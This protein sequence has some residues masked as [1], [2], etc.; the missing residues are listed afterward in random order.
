MVLLALSLAHAEPR[1]AVVSPGGRA[2][3]RQLPRTSPD[4]VQW[5][6][7]GV[8]QPLDLE[9]RS[10]EGVLAW[11]TLGLGGGTW[12]VTAYLEPER[13]QTAS[14]RWDDGDVVFVIDD[15]VPQILPVVGAPELAD[16]LAGEVEPDSWIPPATPLGMLPGR[17]STVA[18]DAA[19]FPAGFAT[20]EANVSGE[21]RDLLIPGDGMAAIDRHR[22][23][24]ELAEVPYEE[25]AALFRLGEA[26]ARL[27]FHR[28][29][30]HYFE[31][32]TELD[33]SWPSSTWLHLARSEV[34]IGRTDEAREHCGRAVES[35]HREPEVL[36]C[37]A[38]VALDTADPP[39]APTGRAL[40]RANARPESLLLAAQLLQMDGRHL[41]AEPLLSAALPALGELAPY[42]WASLGDARF[43]THDGEG[44]RRAWSEVAGHPELGGVIRARKHALVMAEDGPRTWPDHLPEL[45]TMADGG[46]M[47]GAEAL[48]LLAQVAEG[49]GDLDGAAKH[50]AALLKS[51]PERGARSDAPKLLWTA[52]EGRLQQLQR[53]GR[54]VDLL[55]LWGDLWAPDLEREV[56]D[57]TAVRVVARAYEDLELY[58]EALDVHRVLFGIQTRLDEQEP[59]DLVEM[60]RLYLAVGRAEESQRTLEFAR[61]QGVDDPARTWLFEGDALV[62][63]E[64]P[65]EALLAYRKAALSPDTRVAATVRMALV[66]T[67]AGRC[68]RS[69]PA[70][71]DLTRQKVE[72]VELADGEAHLALARCLLSQGRNEDA[73][74]AAREAA[75]RSDDDVTRRYA[76]WL[77]VEASGRAGE[78][79]P[80]LAASLASDDDLWAAL[81]RER[82]AD[83]AFDAELARRRDDR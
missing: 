75:G 3:V 14:W 5:T 40:A 31:R 78:D 4:R 16:L 80:M 22:A 59:N 77:A 37:L 58:D 47:A 28:E 27:G 43:Q 12:V 44:A 46:G 73:A 54:T 18:V 67:E 52:L 79:E 68:D 41:E 1:H 83:G 70:L 8:S 32:V 25:A 24:L 21:L 33:A 9:G 55:A 82:E 72:P 2:R 10:T 48:Y 39:A 50:L 69:V 34:V 66:D 38:L 61:K 81:G 20:W 26:Y 30:A 60:A 76:T 65:D 35:R 63:Q 15:G 42:G 45:Y 74:V 36:E 53:D 11:D 6:V 64:K 57:V 71:L 62:A 23:G 13:D 29:A 51:H 56:Q 7:L 19:T 49:L 17:A